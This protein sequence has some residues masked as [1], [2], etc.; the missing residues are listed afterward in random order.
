[1]FGEERAKTPHGLTV[2]GCQRYLAAN[3]K[4]CC[5]GGR[6]GDDD[7]ATC[8]GIEG[9]KCAVMPTHRKPRGNNILEACFIGAAASVLHTDPNNEWW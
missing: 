1:M 9:T 4:R 6:V 3:G 8:D 7:D 2:T 5:D